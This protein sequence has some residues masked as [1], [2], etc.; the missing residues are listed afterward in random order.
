MF[1][2]KAKKGF[3]GEG[4]WEHFLL[5]KLQPSLHLQ[6]GFGK[7]T[8]SSSYTGRSWAKNCCLKP[9]QTPPKCSGR[10]VFSP[11]LQSWGWRAYRNAHSW[12]ALDLAAE[13]LSN[14]SW[15]K[16]LTANCTQEDSQ[17]FEVLK[18]CGRGLKLLSWQ[19]G[20]SKVFSSKESD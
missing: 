2:E 19:S 5:E 1:Q 15:I 7:N 11:C 16:V 17:E 8:N 12:V 9:F 6:W 13:C 18:C 3:A 10:S 4:W 20:K 14:W